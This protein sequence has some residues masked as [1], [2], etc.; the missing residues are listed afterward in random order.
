[1]RRRILWAVALLLAVA[2]A[3]GGAGAFWLRSQLRS[4]LPQLEGTIRVP[5]LAGR[6]TVTRDAFGV[7]TIRG[8]SRDDL[9]RA[10][11]FLHAQDRFF[12][13]D[14]MRRRA[15]GELSALV[16]RRALETDREIRVHRF[17]AEAERALS[18]LPGPDRA[19]LDAYAAG[20]NTGLTSLGAPPFEY[21]V[22]RQQPEPWRP[23]DSLLV[24]LSMFITLQNSNAAYEATLATIYDVLPR[25]VAEFVS[26]PGTDW[27]TPV[28]GEAFDVPPIPGPEV[29]DLRSRRAG[30]S[31]RLPSSSTQL[32]TR[33][34]EMAG[35]NSWVVSGNLTPDGG[36][37]LANDM[38]LPVRVPNT[39]YRAMLEWPEP[40]NP[41]TVA[42][43][44]PRT[45]APSHPRTLAPSNRRTLIGVTLPG[46]PTLIVG[47]NTHVAWGFTNTYA[48]WGDLVLIEVDP[49]D[50]N[51]YRTPDGWREFQQHRETIAIAG[52]AADVFDVRWT[53]WGPVLGTD[54]RGRLRA[55]KW[56]AH[57]ADQLA[58]K[59]ATPFE[60]VRTVEEALD[61]ASGRGAPG[62]N[63]VVADRSG[64]IGWTIYG[65]IPRRVGFDGRLPSSWADG[66]RGWSGWLEPSEYPRIVDPPGG[67]IWT[68][69]ARV[70]DG[71]MLAKLGDGNYEVGSRARIIRD[72]LMAAGQFTPRDMLGIQ[73]DASAQFTARWRELILR[74]LTPQAAAAAPDRARFRELV[75]RTW[76]G[77]ASPDSAAYGFTREFR[78]EVS[79][80]VMTF[81]LAECY[82]SDPDFDHTTNQRREGPIWK[83]LTERPVHLLDPEF[84]SWDDLLLASIDS[85]IRFAVSQGELEDMSWAFYNVTTYRHP[86]SSGLPFIGRLL[87]MPIRR[88]PGDLFTPRVTWGPNAA[89]QRMVVSPG[90]EADGI[91]HM[92]T[93]QS[94]HPLSPFYANSHDAWVAGE[95]TPFL[96]GPP[97]HQL[98][99]VP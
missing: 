35:S 26:S 48:D 61:D 18:L 93:G 43:S 13:M 55:L 46:I 37:L 49:A 16:G 69:N 98:T 15:A 29:Y 32:R 22:L 77:E 53:I 68:A 34:D 9:A 57:S 96:P 65:S 67:R 64:Q 10:T 91:M 52:E 70:V 47:S 5:G 17:R 45:V 94:G 7:P 42:P 3:G 84:A 86:L 33:A 62:Q 73:L 89:S 54:H 24:V 12:Q 66:A 38:H 59:G 81:L 80:R 78:E 58:A 44:N 75:E 97:V 83:L 23:E 14:L 85:V 27:D 95:P 40:S 87:D 6:V 79:K 76:T 71:E 8:A 19:L 51:R 99:L 92:P 11:G 25:E 1:M 90:R 60:A 63:V 41:G 36:A 21:L 2:I 72:R 50:P 74:T 28:I 31:L 88:M 82:E 56:V 20:V 30:K 39:W 4:S